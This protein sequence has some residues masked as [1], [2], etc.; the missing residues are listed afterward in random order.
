VFV[1]LYIEE[2]CLIGLFFLSTDATG[3]RAKAGLA[4]GAVMIVALILTAL[5][6]IY[7]D[8]FRFKRDYLIYAH[9]STSLKGASS[10]NLN[11]TFGRVTTTVS[12]EQENAG[13]EHGNTSGFHARAFDHPA[14]WKKQPVVWIAD[15]PL[16]IGKFETKRINDLR[17]EASTEYAIMDA[18]GTLVVERGPPDEAWYDGFTAH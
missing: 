8:W 18:K 1:S 5:F 14:L 17:V 10:T 12:E 7:I 3:K 16:G 9:S 15:D 11:T 2:I 6:Q 4:G 13:P